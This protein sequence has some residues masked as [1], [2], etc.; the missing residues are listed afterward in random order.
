MVILWQGDAI[1]LKEIC[2]VSHQM[3]RGLRSGY[4]QKVCSVCQEWDRILDWRCGRHGLGKPASLALTRSMHQQTGRKE[5]GRGVLTLRLEL[6]EA[7][8]VLKVF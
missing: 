2:A 4:S 5:R 8:K 6:R 3:S 7:S 1:L